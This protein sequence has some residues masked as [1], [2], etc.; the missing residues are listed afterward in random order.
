MFD[1]AWILDHEDSYRYQML[2]RFRHD[3]G[4]FLGDAKRN[5]EKLWAKDVKTHIEY[6]K[7]LWNSFTE[8]P[9]WLTWEEIEEYEKAMT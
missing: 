4:Y 9:E 1:L 8:K 2:D 7:A 6:M 5:P 3:C